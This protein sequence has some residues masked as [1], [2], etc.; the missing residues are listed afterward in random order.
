M[1]R[2]RKR[3]QQNCTEFPDGKLPVNRGLYMTKNP[4]FHFWH[5][6][7]VTLKLLNITREQVIYFTWKRVPIECKEMCD[8]R[9]RK[10]GASLGHLHEKEWN[11]NSHGMFQHR[12]I[13]VVK[14]VTKITG[15]EATCSW[16]HVSLT[17]TAVF[18]YVLG[19]NSLKWKYISCLSKSSSMWFEWDTVIWGRFQIGWLEIILI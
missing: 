2:L 9:K 16:M 5:I 1:E 14:G 12:R 7:Q 6:L 13:L 3:C 17:Y 8:N 19:E 15:L 11:C 4:T 18:S 10:T